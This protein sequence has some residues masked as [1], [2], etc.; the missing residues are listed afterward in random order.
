MF[1]TGHR[2]T[3]DKWN[4][5]IVDTKMALSLEIQINI[6]MELNIHENAHDSVSVVTYH[7][8]FSRKVDRKDY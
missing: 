4:D 1:I 6:M 2:K 5:D 8:N 7:R 3:L